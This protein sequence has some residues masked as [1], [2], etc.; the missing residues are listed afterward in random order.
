MKRAGFITLSMMVLVI[1]LVFIGG[2]IARIGHL[3]LPLDDGF[4]HLQ[5]ARQLAVG[6]GLAYND[7]QLVTG[8]TAPLWT[9]LLTLAHLLPG[10]PL[11]WTKAFGIVFLWLTAWLTRSL[12]SELG[13]PNG[14]SWGAA[15]LV[16]ATP[17]LVWSA[18]SGMEILLFTALSLAGLLLVC[19]ASHLLALPIMALAYLARPE[20]ALLVLLAFVFATAHAWST[21]RWRDWWL[22]CFAA[23]AI[24][25]PTLLIY[26]V[27]GGSILP[28]TF[29]VKA[30]GSLGWPDLRYFR[31]V[32]DILFR[33]QP[34]LLF[35]AGTGIVMLASTHRRHAL[36]AIGW[37]LGLP[38][39]YAVLAH[40]SGPPPVGN[41]G[42]YYFPLLPLVI[43]FG[44]LG[45][46]AVVKR[47]RTR[48]LAVGLVLTLAQL[49]LLIDGHR[50]YLQNV[51]DVEASDVAAAHW[52]AT[53]LPPGAAVAAQDA[54]ALKYFLPDHRL[55][56]LA[57]LMSPEI[58]PTL[59]PSDD[60][61]WEQGLFDFLAAR[62]PAVLV[63]FPEYYPMLTRTPGFEPLERFPIPGNITMAG[64]E[65]VIFSTPWH[66]GAVS[67]GTP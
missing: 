35:T 32:I 18:V 53:R 3:G 65:L 2:E 55:I 26:W 1:C 63:V 23:G 27:I 46:H 13:L 39:A 54:G 60:S 62:R 38:V 15:M 7:G 67:G 19:R 59:R 36:V 24:L 11:L 33:S 58:L 8:S 44:L 10:S 57:G 42:R 51:A 34:L 30:G 5:F 52:L 50:R 6:N 64:N 4:I 66:P 45:L 61:Y 12:A 56:D 47:H 40:G 9:A 37:L 48:A 16:P 25:V 21:R 29:Q 28:T 14:W 20:G 22:G 31:L 41:F 17:W 49:A 43:V